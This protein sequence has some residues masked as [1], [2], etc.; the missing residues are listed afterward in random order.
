VKE[1]N[2]IT[3]PVADTEAEQSVIGS[4]IVRP[5]LMP[6]I[7]AILSVE[8]FSLK[9]LKLIYQVMLDLH[10]RGDPV[11]RVTVTGLLRD[12]DLLKEGGPAYLEGLVEECGFST[13][14]EYYA[15]RVREKA[16]LRRYKG[17]L[18]ELYRAA[19][20]RIENLPKFF[21]D[22]T[23]RFM[24]AI[25]GGNLKDLRQGAEAII[26]LGEFLK[27]DL[28][29][30]RTYLEPWL[31]EASIN[32]ISG[33]RGVGKTA[34]AMGLVSAVTRAESFGPWKIVT[35]ASCLY[36]EAEMVQQDT[37]DRFASL[38]QGQTQEGLFILSDH[39]CNLLGLPAANLLDEN[40]RTWLKDE[41]VKRDIKTWVLDNIGAVTPGLD[42]NSREAWSPINR[43]LLDLRF[44]GISTV[45][46]HHEGKAGSQRGTSAR[47]DNLDISISLKRPEGYRPEDGARF[48]CH[49]EKSRIKQAD[50]HLIADVEFQMQTNPEG[51]TVWT[52]KNIK[53]ENKALVLK[54]LDEGTEAKKIAAALGITAARVSQIRKEAVREGLITAAG[55]FTQTGFE[56]LQ[57]T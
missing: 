21:E 18:T 26:E 17:A 31:K 39:Y 1:A 49:F 12:K 53:Q 6:K 47:E 40:W 9:P 45:L 54:M 41:L 2:I 20:T 16:L 28:P 11:D 10:K 50:L 35:P 34:F 32:M 42:E 25:P 30:R 43:W 56:W 24:E 57:K 55:K 4:I 46:L 52:W 8:D 29:K 48:V 15:T 7:S 13:N 5:E 23:T 22:A 19:S 27:I 37:V 44:A 3:F 14:G 33:W 36:F 51:K 38:Y